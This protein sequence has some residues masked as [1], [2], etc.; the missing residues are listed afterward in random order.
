MHDKVVYIPSRGQRHCPKTWTFLSGH[1][2]HPNSE[3]SDLRRVFLSTAI[4]QSLCMSYGTT[5]NGN[6]EYNCMRP[7]QA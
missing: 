2:R 7:R 4:W 5:R 6:A 3:S 1:D